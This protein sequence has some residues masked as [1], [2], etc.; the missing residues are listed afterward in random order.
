MLRDV[1]EVVLLK[2]GLHTALAAKGVCRRWREYA[3]AAIKRWDLLTSAW[4]RGGVRAEA[5][6]V[7]HH[8]DDYVMGNFD[9]AANL[10]ALD[11]GGFVCQNM[12]ECEPQHNVFDADMNAAHLPLGPDGGTIRGAGRALT[13]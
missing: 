3:T 12:I 7:G 2:G 6:W 10:L 11:S 8:T 13:M 9:T 4:V 1:M 5:E